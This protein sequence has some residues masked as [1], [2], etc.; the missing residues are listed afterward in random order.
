VTFSP[1]SARRTK[2][3]TSRVRRN[4]SSN[5]MAFHCCT[6]AGDDAPRPSTKPPGAASDM[7]A[8]VCASSAGPRVNA[9]AM[10]TPTRSDGCHAA[11]SASGVKP[12]WA[13]ASP[14]HTSVNPR[15]TSRS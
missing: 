14:L 13:L 15:A 8:A 3:N 4:G 9:G 6:I 10:A 11:A 2:R 7:V 1:V 12:S 5:G